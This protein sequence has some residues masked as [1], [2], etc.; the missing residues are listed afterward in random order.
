MTS[1]ASDLNPFVTYRTE[2]D[3]YQQ[4]RG[5]GWSDDQYIELVHNLDEQ[6][7]QVDGTGFVETPLVTLPTP[8]E[9]PVYAKVE[10]GGVGGSHKAR[11]L[12][13]LLLQST[14]ASGEQTSA[15]EW[16]IASCGNAALAAAVI[17][18]SADRPLRVFVPTDASQVVIDRLDELEATVVVCPRNDET[19][20]DP[21][22]E[23]LRLA[24]ANG[25]APFTVQGPLCPEVFDGARTLGLELAA[26]IAARDMTNPTDVYL[27][28]GGGAF[29]TSVMD[30]MQR[31]GLDEHRLHPVQPQRAHP[32]AA[33]WERLVPRLLEA[34]ELDD[35]GNPVDLAMKLA[36]PARDGAFDDII[37]AADDVMSPWP[38]APTSVASGILDDI[39]YD[40]RPLVLHQLRS[41]GW[42]LLPSEDDFMTAV[43]VA[44]PHVSPPPDA[45]GAAG[46]AGAL[47]DDAGQ[48][49]A[50]D[51]PA[52]VVLSGVDREWE[53]SHR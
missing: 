35:P 49:L 48:L 32:Y 26:Q 17:A 3:T 51:S 33:A 7:R 20:G 43:D 22:F 16:A 31:G 29:A 15:P 47:I 12:F 1:A 30:G 9:R 5:A 23:A 14:I 4:A 11:H 40:W 37:A 18:R 38:A 50:A 45:T 10:T 36:Q 19:V 34:A 39:T 13:G 25:A 52:L 46:L 2:L 21:C 53:R 28:V 24:L 8:L 42:P 41:A 27:Q 6:V 44:R